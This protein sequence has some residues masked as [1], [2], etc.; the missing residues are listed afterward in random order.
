MLTL[1]NSVNT[2][3][4]DLELFFKEV[5]KIALGNWDNNLLDIAKTEIIKEL[6][7]EDVKFEFEELKLDKNL[8]EVIQYIS[9][10]EILK[11][12]FNS[13]KT[14]KIEVL[15]IPSNNQELVFKLVASPCPFALMKIGDITEWIKNKLTGYEISEKFENESYFKQINNSDDINILI[16]SRSFYEGWDSNRPNIILFINIGKGIDAKK[17]VL[18]SIGRGVRIEPLPNK[19]KRAKFL[20]NNHEI[21]EN[22]FSN[23]K[24]NIQPLE[25]LFVFGTKADNLKE[26]LATLK[27]EKP[28]ELIG[29]L[30]EINP[31]AEDKLLLIPKYRNSDK[32][33]A[34]EKDVV[35]YPIHPEDYELVKNY[36]NF[37]SDKILLCKFDC[38][39]RVL[40]K[41]KEGFNGKKKEFFNENEKELKINNP[42]FLIQNIF[43]HFGSKSKE[44]D[45]FK[46]LE[47]E[48]IHFKQISITSDKLDSL[49]EKIENVKKA[50]DKDSIKTQLRNRF[51][52]REID[53]EEYTS[54][55]ENISTNIVK[56]AEVTYN[57]NERL[58][59]IYL[60]NHYYI[61]VVLSDSERLDFIRHII[62]YKSEVEFIEQLENYLKKD[63]NL[64]KKFDWWLFSKIDETLDEVYIPYY[65][66]KTNKIERFKPDFIF[67]LKRGNE[68]TILFVDPKSTE[69]TDAFRKSDGYSRIFEIETAKGKIS[70][71]FSYNG[72]VV[73]VILKFMAKDCSYIHDIAQKRY[74]FDNIADILNNF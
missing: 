38:Y 68:Y 11:Y 7:S 52:K 50:K 32:I 35:K 10:N 27:Q 18:Q 67:W 4:S 36:F 46:K 39:L 65:N 54:Q 40:S 13:E 42:E 64:F 15:K 16:G 21:D 60:A 49:K 37:V 47:E 71:N 33:I 48:I 41:L 28:E 22:L 70:K 43:K 9:F 1:V 69:Y 2:E 73:N 19:R 31:A 17:F 24:E 62:K 61:P 26:V 45:C 5:E 56:E 30:F 59:I 8:I 57:A 12:I 55:I 74:W 63:D 66:S 34:D 25:A 23:I 44:F 51:Y 29:N 14:G 72:F 53:I 3:D 6:S 58:K 20:Y